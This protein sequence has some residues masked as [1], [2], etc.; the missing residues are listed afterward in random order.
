MRPVPRLVPQ[1]RRARLDAVVVL[2]PGLAVGAA[3]NEVAILG[4]APDV[5][6]G[7]KA[8]LNLASFSNR[9]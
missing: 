8:R 1:V 6:R 2:E 3:Y 9:A 5:G 4:A 7:R